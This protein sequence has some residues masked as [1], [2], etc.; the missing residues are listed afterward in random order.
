MMA[1][2]HKE[3]LIHQA[4]TVSKPLPEYAEMDMILDDIIKLTRQ[5]EAEEAEG[6]GE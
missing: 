5:L 2:S 1:M 4:K 6:K 3:W